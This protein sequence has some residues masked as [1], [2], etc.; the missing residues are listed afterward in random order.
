MEIGHPLGAQGI[1][2]DV[3]DKFFKVRLF[4]ADNRLIAVLEQVSRS[5]VS[6]VVACGISGQQP[7]HDGG[8]CNS[9]GSEKKVGVVQKKGPCITSC[10]ALR[11]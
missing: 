1:E 2:M 11:E 4:L 5:L 6:M 8:Q 9:A 10:V 3:P 7:G